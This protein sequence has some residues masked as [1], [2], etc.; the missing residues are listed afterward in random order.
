MFVPCP[1]FELGPCSINKNETV[2]TINNPSSWTS[3]A[4]VIFLDQPSEQRIVCSSERWGQTADLPASRL[5][6]S[7]SSQRRLLVL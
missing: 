7:L 4:N 5:F 6:V 1:V 3:K 2:G